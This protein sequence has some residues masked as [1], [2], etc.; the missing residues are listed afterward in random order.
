MSVLIS[1]RLDNTCFC[2][3]FNYSHVGCIVMPP[4]VLNCISLMASNVEH[5]FMCLLSIC[6][7]SLKNRKKPNFILLH[8]DVQWIA[9]LLRIIFPTK[10]FWDLVRKLID[11]SKCWFW[12]VKSLPLMF[13]SV[14]MSATPCLH[15]YS[16]WNWEVNPPTWSSF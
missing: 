8:V 12:I 15:Y 14:F 13:M 9:L 6:I 2:L 7:S 16:F 5:L 1:H 3:S 11:K 4:W 10:L